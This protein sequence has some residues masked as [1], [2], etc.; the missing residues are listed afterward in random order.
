MGK[1]D[2]LLGRFNDEDT[3]RNAQ[4]VIDKLGRISDKSYT[5]MYHVGQKQI[6]AKQDRSLGNR[7]IKAR[8]KADKQNAKCANGA[9]R[10]RKG[11]SR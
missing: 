5:E 2:I 8:F 11:I 9:L 10:H 4:S 7:L 3:A 1:L 6:E